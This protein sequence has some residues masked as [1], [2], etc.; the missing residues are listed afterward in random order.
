MVV[1]M[2]EFKTKEK[3]PADPI[4]FSIDGR[5]MVFRNPGWAPIVMMN[6]NA[7]PMEIARTYLDWLGAGM[8][9]ED[10]QHVLDRLL[11]PTDSF[12]LA[13]ITDVYLG[14]VEEVTGRPIV[15]L[16]DSSSSLETEPSTDGRHLVGSTLNGSTQEG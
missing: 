9:E 1:A 13:D 11:D 7:Q 2:R 15:P 4:E 12:D 5:E 6:R 8:S 10:S 3:P 16:T 14:I